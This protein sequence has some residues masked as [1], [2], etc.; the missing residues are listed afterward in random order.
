MNKLLV[1]LFASAFACV[2][3]S[4]LA[5]TK[6]APLP[7]GGADNDLMP[8]TKMDTE[9]AKAARAAA[10]AKWDAMT[11]EQRAA[12]RKAAQQKKVAEATALDFVA[13][14]NMYY[15]TK[16]GAKDAA[17]SKAQPVPTK[18]ERVKEGAVLSKEASKGGGN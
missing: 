10:K 12:T 2:S 6:P 1:A 4:A 11:P 15:D 7:Q 5:Q 3:A 8:I 14:E 17:A 18:A 9:Q 13:S 16:M